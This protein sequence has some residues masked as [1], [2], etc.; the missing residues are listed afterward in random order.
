MERGDLARV[1]VG[2]QDIPLSGTAGVM[3][4]QMPL[5]PQ[6][7][8][9]IVDHV[10]PFGCIMAGDWEKDAPWRKRNTSR[11]ATALEDATPD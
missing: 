3:N 9:S 5:R 2:V 4:H 6:E 1:F 10:D 7:P 8:G 11:L